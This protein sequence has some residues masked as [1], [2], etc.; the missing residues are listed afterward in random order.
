MAVKSGAPT[1]KPE[2][3]KGSQVSI[4]PVG[5]LATRQRRPGYI[6]LLVVL[7]VGLG[8]LGGYL[9]TT[10]GSKTTVLIVARD[11]LPGQVIQ[12]S[13][14]T[15]ASL[16]GDVRA[17]AA[18]AA[19]TVVG[20]RAAVELLPGTLLQRSMVAAGPKIQAGQAQVGL[21]L[22][23]GAIPAT[24]LVPGDAV[25]VLRL[26]SKSLTTQ[27]PPPDP[28]LITAATVTTAIPDP[29]H[30]GGWLITVTVPQEKAAAVAGAAGAGDAV[31]VQVSS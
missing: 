17:I 30:Q 29:T 2:K 3:V 14:L 27:G 8:M 10:A 13:D 22:P 1:K 9:Y 24:G 26:P 28:T 23:P 20:Q 16:A 12:R 19:E 25:Q 21:Q 15:T 18:S 4:A 6:A 31:L 5:G 11:V 7:V